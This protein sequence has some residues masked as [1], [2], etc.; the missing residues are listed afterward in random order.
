MMNDNIELLMGLAVCAFFVILLSF[1]C[2]EAMTKNACL[3]AGYPNSQVTFTFDRYCIQ[4]VD[5]TDV[6]VP[7][8]KVK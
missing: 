8:S 1:G 7:F 3:K 6:V 4:R 5:Q 2:T